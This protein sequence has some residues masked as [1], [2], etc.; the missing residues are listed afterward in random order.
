MVIGRSAGHARFTHALARHQL[1]AF[2][3]GQ[4]VTDFCTGFFLIEIQF[5]HRARAVFVIINRLRLRRIVWTS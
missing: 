5:M 3:C 1:L 4:F 2:L